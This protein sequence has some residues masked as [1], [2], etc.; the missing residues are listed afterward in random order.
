[1]NIVPKVKS[2]RVCLSTWIVEFQ[3]VSNS[4]QVKTQAVK[5]EENKN[6]LATQVLLFFCSVPLISISFAVNSVAAPHVIS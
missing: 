5:E 1:M 3:C 6:N 2:S 4:K